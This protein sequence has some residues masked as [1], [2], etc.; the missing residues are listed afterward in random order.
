MEGVYSIDFVTKNKSIIVSDPFQFRLLVMEEHGVGGDVFVE[1]IWEELRFW[2]GYFD[3]IHFQFAEKKLLGK[4]A[5][6]VKNTDLVVREKILA[7]LDFWQEAFGGF[8]GKH[9]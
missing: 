9:P 4:T 3:H 7:L 2:E 6:S 8:K 5:N 1:S